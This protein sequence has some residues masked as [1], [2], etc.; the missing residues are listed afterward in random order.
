MNDDTSL[1]TRDVTQNVTR[2]QKSLDK[3]VL[4]NPLHL[5]LFMN[6][7]GKSS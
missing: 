3:S 2:E 7:D 4:R 6:R 5:P 1:G